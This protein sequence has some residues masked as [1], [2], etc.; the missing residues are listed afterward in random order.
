MDEVVRPPRSEVL[1]G[2]P[3]GFDCLVLG[4]LVF[5]A[6]TG[7]TSPLLVHIARDDR[8]LDALAAG[9]AFFAPQVR[10]IEFPAWDTVPYDRI[11]P[12]S[13]IVATRVAALARLAAASRKGPTLVLTTVNSILQRVPPRQF[14]RRA[15][16]NIAAGQR[17]DMNELAQRLALAG[18]QRTGLVMEPGEYALRGGILDLYPPGRQLPV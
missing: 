4:R 9:L 6:A 14:I 12:N 7:T 15:L 16:K 2:V 17:I 8:R 3:E 11:G 10:V 5:E 13:E 18:F 1:A